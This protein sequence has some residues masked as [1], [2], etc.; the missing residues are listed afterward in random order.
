[1]ML[2]WFLRL[3]CD[4]RYRSVSVAA[5]SKS[6]STLGQFRKPPGSLVANLNGE[7]VGSPAEFSVGSGIA[8]S[9]RLRTLALLVSTV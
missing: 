2:H 5:T 3:L 9:E 1:L 6:A 4:K 7:G 8:R